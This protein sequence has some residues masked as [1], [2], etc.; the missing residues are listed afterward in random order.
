MAGLSDE[1]SMPASEAA[2]IQPELETSSATATTPSAITPD[3]T[4]MPAY[5]ASILPTEP[6]RSS[7]TTPGNIT[8]NRVMGGTFRRKAAK[9]TYPWLSVAAA[10]LMS[11]SLLPAEDE[12]VISAVPV[13]KKPRVEVPLPATKDKAAN[14]SKIT[15]LNAETVA[16][17]PAD[18]DPMPVRA[19]NASAVGA[20]SSESTLENKV[21]L[22]RVVEPTIQMKHKNIG[23]EC[24]KQEVAAVA[25]MQRRTTPSKKTR[26]QPTIDQ[27]T[28]GSTFFVK[29]PTKF[30]R[31]ESSRTQACKTSLQ[32]MPTQLPAGYIPSDLDVCCGRGKS[33]WDMV[34]NVKFQ[35]VLDALSARY[36]AAPLKYDKHDIIDSVVDEFRR[37]GGHFLKEQQRSGSGCWVDIGDLAARIKVGHWL[38]NVVGNPSHYRRPLNPDRDEVEL[39]SVVK[40]TIQM[41]KNTREKC[42]KNDTSGANAPGKPTIEMRT[43]T[44]GEERM[45]Q[46]TRRVST[47]PLVDTPAKF[48]Y[49]DYRGGSHQNNPAA[50]PNSDDVE[51]MHLVKPTIQMKLNSGKACRQQEGAAVG[52]VMALAQPNTGMQRSTSSTGSGWLPRTDQKSDEL[53]RPPISTLPLLNSPT[54]F[55]SVNNSLTQAA[56]QNQP[57][58]M[59]AG[60]IPSDLD[61]CCGHGKQ[62]WSLAGNVKY[63]QVINAISARYVAAPLRFDRHAEILLVVEMIR[64]QGGHFLKE[65]EHIGSGYWV[66]IGNLASR[67]KVKHSLRSSSIAHENKPSEMPAGYIPSAFDVCCGHGKRYWDMVG[68]VKYRQVI[69]AS[70]ARYVAAAPLQNGNHDAVESVVE[71]IRRQGGHFL[72]EQEHIGSGCWVDIGNLAS[73]VNVKDSF[74]NHMS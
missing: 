45:R 31:V 35:Q 48:D 71:T 34:G 66:D 13:A 26:W 14:K 73:R 42:T 20:S 69:H 58:K 18:A 56:R 67:A 64:R 44:T 55:K 70:W 28:P 68:N 16:L 29:I 15:S 37:Q 9:R 52:A 33:H 12:E 65:Q 22:I 30:N 74:R 17:P 60:Y 25:A 6:E 2:S 1:A 47:L 11:P 32:N 62:Y 4:S 19:S 54:T 38:R 23:K 36:V 50:K 24:K 43:S 39:S 3:E 49:A 8:T 61:V 53:V 59:P 5:E 7:A 21:E 27:Q 63:R 51:L 57:S 46:D 41:R 40:P 10:A 72:K